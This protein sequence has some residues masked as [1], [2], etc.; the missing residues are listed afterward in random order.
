MSVANYN[1]G[2]E[3]GTYGATLLREENNNT[4]RLQVSAAGFFEQQVTRLKEMPIHHQG[5][6]GS[7][8]RL[9]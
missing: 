1:T 3:V 2:N 7:Q 5:I 4:N 6:D 8:S 9:T